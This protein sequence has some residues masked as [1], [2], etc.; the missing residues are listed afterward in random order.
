M[1]PKFSVTA[2][3]DFLHTRNLPIGYDGF[4]EVRF[5]IERGDAR[6]FNLETVFPDDIFSTS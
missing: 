2:A 4:H 1:R 6:F 5:F 3:G